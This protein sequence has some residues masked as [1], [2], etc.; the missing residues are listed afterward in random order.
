MENTNQIGLPSETAET[1]IEYAGSELTLQEAATDLAN[2]HDEIDQYQAGALTLANELED[3]QM[4]A[5]AEGNETLA[6]TAY[7]LK[8]SA[9][10]VSTRID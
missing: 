7:Q 1:T 5:E 8:Q 4:T 9:I 10:A 3:L 6:Q 2:A